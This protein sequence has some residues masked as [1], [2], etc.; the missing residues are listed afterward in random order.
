MPRTSRKLKATS[1]EHERLCNYC[2]QSRPTRG[3]K[4]HVRSCKKRFLEEQELKQ[5]QQLEPR[6]DEETAS[7][8]YIKIVHHPH[9][10]KVPTIVPLDAAFQESQKEAV[11]AELDARRPWYPFKTRA[12]FEYTETALQGKLTSHV[13]NAQL[14]GQHNG[15]VDG[16]SRITLKNAGDMNQFKRGTVSETFEGQTYSF[17]F[18]YRDPWEWILDIVTDPTLADA[19]LWYPVEKYVRGQDGRFVR[20]YDDLNTGR[21]W[22]DIQNSLPTMEGLPHCYLP[23]HIW[24][25][26]G[27]VSSHVQMHP[28]VGRC[29]VVPARIRNASGNG[30]GVLFGYMPIVK[31]PGDPRTRTQAQKVAFAKFKRDVYHKVLGVIFCSLRQRSHS[32]EAV[33]C[34]DLILR[35]LFPGF[36]VLSLDG[37][38][39]CIICN[40]RASLADFPCPRCLAHQSMLHVLL[41]HQ[42]F[43]QR[44]SQSMQKVYQ[45]AL[46]AP[47]KV[48]SEKILQTHG[49][50]LSE[51]VFWAFANSD[52]YRAYSYDTLHADDLGK[53]GKHIYPLLIEV[54]TERGT[55]AT[56]A[57]NMAALPRWPGLKHFEAVTTIEFAD[58]QSYLDILKC[59]LPCVVQLL[60]KDSS[61]V[62]CIR[63][64]LR[65]RMLIGLHVVTED[66]LIRVQSYMDK[67]QLYCAKLNREHGK[68]FDFPKQHAGTH[69]ISDIRLKG[70]T[71][72][73]GTRVG[74]GFHQEAQDAY[75]IG[76]HRNN[77]VQ[78]TTYDANQEAI[79]LIRMSINDSDKLGSPMR[80]TTSVTFEDSMCGDTFYSGFNNKLRAELAAVAQNV[81]NPIKIRPFRCLYL[82]YQSLE[83][84]TD[85]RNI[86]RCNPRYFDHPRYDCVLINT[87]SSD[88]VC[89][90]LR[91]LFACEVSGQWHHVALIQKF[92][93]SSWTPRTKWEGC[94]VYEESQSTC[95]V[96]VKYFIR[97]VYMVPAFQGKAHTYYLV[98]SVD[99]D[100]VLRAGV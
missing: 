39:A 51:N 22:W 26:K 13:I 33:F 24:L 34:G 62:H 49:L 72:N 100:M 57:Q 68:S 88:M 4:T 69:V 8:H 50:H 38:E 73:Y 21:E 87:D 16:K 12:D 27:K 18:S 19:L 99:Y 81:P 82:H 29:G 86:L 5:R 76:N 20:L 53:W 65:Y 55:V 64:Y 80:L 85:C 28:I 84:W 31:D 78:M 11:L 42:A 94:R 35:V 9:T 60:P 23:L 2:Q 89:A 56:F 37:E 15:W 30:G 58:G 10:S 54:L 43:E 25:D 92:K 97:A 41:A 14:H 61:L 48:A 17:E 59:V 77:D 52:P 6:C 45:Q 47:T 90:R 93:R 66:H 83:D 70:A 95:F 96:M 44:T 98:D 32:G 36:L 46:H 7:E 1:S 75:S 79:A 74:E 3:F 71:A 67:Y 91:G 63:A 40:C